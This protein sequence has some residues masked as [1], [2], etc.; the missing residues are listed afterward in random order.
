M[1]VTAKCTRV[2]AWWAVEVPEVQGVFTQAKRLTQVREMVAD[3]VALMLDLDPASVEVSLHPVLPKAEAEAVQR[4]T[5][6]VSRATEA[7]Q[8][9]SVASREAVAALRAMKLSTRET[10]ELL[11]ITHQRV[12]QLEARKTG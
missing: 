12:S 8:E 2:G 3:A 11:S 9:A 10:A 7:A 6:A 4:V 5:Q 1:N